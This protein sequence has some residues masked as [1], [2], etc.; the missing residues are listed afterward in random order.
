MHTLLDLRAHSLKRDNFPVLAV[1][2]LDGFLI[3]DATMVEEDENKLKV[4]HNGDQMM[5]PFQCD[6]CHL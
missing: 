6:V 2:D 1:T 5:V 4:A 3:N